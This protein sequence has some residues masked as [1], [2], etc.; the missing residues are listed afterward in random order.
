MIFTSNQYSTFLWFS[1][2]WHFTPGRLPG[3][4]VLA[5]GA[6]IR[7]VSSGSRV[8]LSKVFDPILLSQYSSSDRSGCIQSIDYHYSTCHVI[9]KAYIIWIK[10]FLALPLFWTTEQCRCIL[11][12]IGATMPTTICK[13][14]DLSKEIREKIV[15]HTRLE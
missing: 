9:Y 11:C 1:M 7:M 10:F 6:Y 13:T 8:G 4:C 5:N 2:I 15:H 12:I 3:T 14:K